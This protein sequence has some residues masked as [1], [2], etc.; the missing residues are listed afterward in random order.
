M[1]K[2]IITP[3]ST[4]KKLQACLKC[5]LIQ[6][7]DQYSKNNWRCPNHKHCG[8]VGLD[9]IDTLKQKTT[10]NF[11]G[12]VAKIGEGWVSRWLQIEEP[13]LAGVYAIDVKSDLK[14]VD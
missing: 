4:T 1:L 3:D 11:S 6:S 7:T 13:L 10:T 5:K 9:D 12:F 8:T 2:N 14:L